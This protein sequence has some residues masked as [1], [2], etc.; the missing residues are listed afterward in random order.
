MCGPGSARRPASRRASCCGPR[1]GRRSPSRSPR[2]GGPGELLRTPRRRAFAIQLAACEEPE[3]RSL[4]VDLGRITAPTTVV[5]GRHDLDF[6]RT[7][8]Q[9]LAA[10]LPA[11]KLV[12]LPW[13]G[14][15]PNL[16]RPDETTELIRRAIRSADVGP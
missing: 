1:S 14:H 12:E 13:A 4:D 16:E 11:A 3:E 5:Y 9:H 6:F 7:V 15:L 2:A 8:A 10:G